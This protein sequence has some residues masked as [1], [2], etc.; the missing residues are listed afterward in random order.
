MYFTAKYYQKA[1]NKEE[2]DKLFGPPNWRDYWKKSW[3]DVPDVDALLD[4]LEREGR[5][6]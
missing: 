1:D 5:S 2:Y 6:A 3:G 4:E